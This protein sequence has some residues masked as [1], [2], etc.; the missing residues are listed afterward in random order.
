[1]KRCVLAPIPLTD[2]L[3]GCILKNEIA[4]EYVL[5]WS[6]LV[7][8]R[9]RPFPLARKGHGGFL[10]DSLDN[11]SLKGSSVKGKSII[12]TLYV[13][14]DKTSYGISKSDKLITFIT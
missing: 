8:R 7:V 10:L 2:T 13:V 1:M 4:A 3:R 14:P 9:D 5:N 12:L 11:P 6:V